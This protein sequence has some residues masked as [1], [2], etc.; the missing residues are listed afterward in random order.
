MPSRIMKT[1][2]QR[3]PIELWGGVECT[4]NRVRNRYFNQLDRSGHWTRGEDLDL[5]AGLGLRTLRFPVL[6]ETL[7]PDS[8]D[9][10]DW[11]WPDKRLAKLKSLGI[12]PIVGLLH[13][14]SGPRYTDLIDPFFPE[15]FARFALEV[16]RR[17]PW[18]D[19]YTPINEPL[20]TARFS[21]L[22]GHWFPH[23]Q[24]D[25]SFACAILNE[26]RATVL[27]ME[28]IREI[29]PDAI[30][31]Q[32]EDLGRTFST[33]EMK[34]QADFDNERRWLT[35]DLLLGRVQ[36]KT[37]MWNY[38]IWA[39]ATLDDLA[40]F[41]EQRCRVDIL[42]I[43]HYVTSDRYLDENV[44]SY[45]LEV[46]GRN[47]RHVYADDAAVRA[48]SIVSGGFSAA[49]AE[50]HNRYALPI[51]LTE[52]H[53]GSTVDEQM[54]WFHEAWQSAETTRARGMDVRAVTAWAL[55]GSSDWNSLVTREDG[56]YEAGAF[57]LRDG[58][59]QPTALADLLTT[60]VRENRFTNPSLKSRGWWRKRS[61]LRPFVRDALA[62]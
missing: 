22:Y 37:P 13:H 43:N 49:I 3:T 29:N 34:Y 44:G 23:K 17:Y 41:E 8:L 15:K 62:A 10:I 42:G 4:V 47:H 18:I 16:A 55:L 45:P 54:R 53:L 35:W 25:R 48:R 60:L 9:H 12:R 50:A 2:C 39:G 24:D 33:R 59:P 28:K 46:R 30:L 21:T 56:N 36:R 7:A 11:L 1:Q 40:F 51:A 6:W 58:Q 19:A 38:L 20:T 52:V 5:F 14:G 61:R 27:A 26:S 57:E 32:T 31:I